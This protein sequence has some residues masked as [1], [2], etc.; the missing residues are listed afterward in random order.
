MKISVVTVCYNSAKTIGDTLESFFGQ[1]HSEKEL[2]VIDGVSTDG[3]LKVIRSFPQER[4]IVI[5]EPD[6]GVY[7][8]MN[9]GL[10]YYTGE[11]VG[12]LN[13]DDCFSDPYALSAISETLHNVDITYG[14]IDI[15]TD[16]MS[17]QV[18]RAWKSSTHVPG[19]F[20]TGWTPAHPTFYTRRRVVDAVGRFDLRFR[21]ASDYDYMLRAL[22]LHGFRSVLCDRV[23]VRMK[24][25]GISTNG[26]RA[27]VT[28]NLEAR[29]SRRVRFGASG[30]DWALI[31]KPLRKL[32][33][34]WP[35]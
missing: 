24:R 27:Y 6:S 19:S 10:E 25:G 5:S 17:K 35:R 34:L 8:A 29:R 28:G 23:L 1:D 32:P 9:K 14:H 30:F 21:V 15:V 31:A 4:M 12:F 2:V 18:V 7:D 13:S 26:I 16:H 33:Q 22:E 3:T 11:A 20:R